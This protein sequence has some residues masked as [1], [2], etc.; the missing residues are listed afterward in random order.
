LSEAGRRPRDQKDNK[1]VPHDAS[2]RKVYT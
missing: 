2:S 1:A